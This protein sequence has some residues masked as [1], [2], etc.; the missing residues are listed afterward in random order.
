MRF[1]QAEKIEQIINKLSLLTME[2][3][4]YWAS[5]DLLDMRSEIA[6][7]EILLDSLLGARQ[8]VQDAILK[9]IKFMALKGYDE[10]RIEKHIARKRGKAYEID[11][12][13]EFVRKTRQ[14]LLN[15]MERFDLSLSRGWY[16]DF[17]L[18]EPTQRKREYPLRLIIRKRELAD[19]ITYEGGITF[20]AKDDTVAIDNFVDSGEHPVIYT[21][22][23]L[24]KKEGRVIRK[25]QQIYKLDLTGV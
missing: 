12:R 22:G 13:A 4:V 18:D 7:K 8:S 23:I 25:P 17:T 21:L 15:R 9:D 20:A 10:E 14:R 16:I 1:L 19:G 3:E 6:D 24:L 5:V 11:K 2:G